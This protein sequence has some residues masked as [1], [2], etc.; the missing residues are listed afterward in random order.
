MVEIKSKNVASVG[1]LCV[2]CGS[3]IRECPFG[4]ISVPRGVRASVD[5]SKCVGCGKCAKICPASVIEI[6]A[7]EVEN[8]S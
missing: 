2:A 8:E 6:I 4:A 7:R 1:A 5:L 3:C